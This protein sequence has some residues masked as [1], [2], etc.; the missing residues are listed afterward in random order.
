LYHGIKPTKEEQ[1]VL[2]ES[3]Y[4]SH[5]FVRKDGPY[6]QFSDLRGATFVFNDSQS[7]SG[8]HC[9]RFHIFKNFPQDK[10]FFGKAIESGGHEKSLNILLNGTADVAAID[11]S[12]VWN[13]R[14]KSRTW[15]RALNSLCPLEDTPTLGPYPG[16]P[17]VVLSDSC[18]SQREAVRNALC[19]AGSTQL[20]PLG[21]KRIVPINA[22][23]YNEVAH[24][25]ELSK[26][27]PD[28]AINVQNAL[29]GD[30]RLLCRSFSSSSFS[31]VTGEV[32][33]VDDKKRKYQRE[34]SS[35][36]IIP[37]KLHRIS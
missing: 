31:E 37:Y 19:S 7:L 15:R 6:K 33:I 35:D 36:G 13:L 20:Q 2:G 10:P 25:L 24:L 11:V 29:S 17:F 26:S 12:V 18:I 5:V 9:M 28:V 22:E 4:R 3:M 1:K 14:R 34:T 32:K 8:Y 30:K 16:Q 27:Q 21:W 23:A